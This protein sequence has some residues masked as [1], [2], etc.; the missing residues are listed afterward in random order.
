MNSIKNLA[1]VE[2][3]FI[4]NRVQRTRDAQSFKSKLW[5]ICT[6]A[7]KSFIGSLKKN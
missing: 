5:C 2:N 4:L 1:L 6:I 7:H 3:S